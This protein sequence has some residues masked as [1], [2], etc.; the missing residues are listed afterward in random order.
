MEGGEKPKRGRVN[1]MLDPIRKLRN[2]VAHHEP[3]LYFNLPKHDAN[4]VT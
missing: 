2:R 1:A 4:M 3:I